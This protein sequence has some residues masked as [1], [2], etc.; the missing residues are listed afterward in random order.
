MRDELW[1]KKT[2]LTISGTAKKSIKNIGLTKTQGKQ[3]VVIG[4]QRNNFTKKGSS[5]RSSGSGSRSNPSA[6]F[7]RGAPSKPSFDGKTPPIGNDFERRKLAEQRAKKDWKEIM[8]V[9]S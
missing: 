8:K 6:T 2:K 4:K 3:T 1:K 9:E 5:Y 7:S